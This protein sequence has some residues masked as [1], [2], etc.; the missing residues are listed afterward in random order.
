MTNDEECKSENGRVMFEG[1]IGEI[2]ACTPKTRTSGS[3][4]CWRVKLLESDVITPQ[5]VV[6]A[7]DTRPRSCKGVVSDNGGRCGPG[8][9]W[10][11][12]EKMRRQTKECDY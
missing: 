9:D 11:Y 8:S 10:K 7:W 2:D 4:F 1:D 12:Q 3:R 5:Y 6:K